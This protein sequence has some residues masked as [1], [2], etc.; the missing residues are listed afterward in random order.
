MTPA[1]RSLAE[2]GG[3]DGG[4]SLPTGRTKGDV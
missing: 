2:S 1:I 4:S 3:L